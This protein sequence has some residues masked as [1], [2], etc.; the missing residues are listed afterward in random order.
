[1]KQFIQTDTFHSKG[2]QSVVALV[3]VATGGICFL[4]SCISAMVIMRK[5]ISDTEN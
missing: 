1:M 2:W 5:N 3:M 4:L